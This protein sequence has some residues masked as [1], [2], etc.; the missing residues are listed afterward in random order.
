MLLVVLKRCLLLEEVGEMG[1][2]LLHPLL[3]P[4]YH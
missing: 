2:V 4:S 3:L 1:L